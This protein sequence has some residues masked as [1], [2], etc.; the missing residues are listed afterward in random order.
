MRLRIECTSNAKW[1]AV[2]RKKSINEM[3]CT[4][5]HAVMKRASPMRRDGLVYSILET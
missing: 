1:E 2:S 3:G 5:V 4:M